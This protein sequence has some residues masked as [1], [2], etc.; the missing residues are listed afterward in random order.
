MSSFISYGRVYGSGQGVEEF[1]KML[2][3]RKAVVEEHLKLDTSN[4][5]AL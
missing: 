2:G 4:G 1:Q 5:A 3:G